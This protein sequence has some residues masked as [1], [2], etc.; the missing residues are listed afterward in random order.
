MFSSIDMTQLKPENNFEIKVCGR[1]G[2]V[3]PCN[4][5][6]VVFGNKVVFKIDALAKP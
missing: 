5:F 4:M 6:V 2:G 3:V 1:G